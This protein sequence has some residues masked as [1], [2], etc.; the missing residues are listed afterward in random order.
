LK[1]NVILHNYT[2]VILLWQKCGENTRVEHKQR[3][4]SHWNNPRKGR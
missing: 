4:S 1:K 2:S 3:H